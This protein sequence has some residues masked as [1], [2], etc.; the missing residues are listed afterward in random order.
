MKTSAVLLSVL[1]LSACGSINVY[2]QGQQAPAGG[3]APPAKKAP[4]EASVLPAD[5][6]DAGVVVDAGPPAPVVVETNNIDVS[7]NGQLK[8]FAG[9][10]ILDGRLRIIGEVSDFTPL[11]DVEEIRGELFITKATTE[12]LSLPNLRI[13]GGPISVNACPNLKELTLGKLETAITEPDVIPLVF[14]FNPHLP[15][16]EIDALAKRTGLAVP[17]SPDLNNDSTAVCH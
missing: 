9:A 6:E 4:N 17:L 10:T 12:T 13:V 2:E 11:K 7:T 14:D 5:P 16:C 15:Q 8:A 1:A 3:S